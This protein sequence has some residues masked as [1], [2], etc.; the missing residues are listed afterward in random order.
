VQDDYSPGY[1]LPSEQFEDELTEMDQEDVKYAM[2]FDKA[3]YLDHVNQCH[4]REVDVNGDPVRTATARLFGGSSSQQIDI[5]RSAVSCKDGNKPPGAVP[6]LFMSRWGDNDD[7]DFKRAATGQFSRPISYRSQIYN[8][9]TLVGN[10]SRGGLEN[11]DLGLFRNKNTL[12][13]SVAKKWNITF[14]KLKL[15]YKNTR[16]TFSNFTNMVKSA[17]FRYQYGGDQLN[18][19]QNTI[20]YNS[21]ATWVGKKPE[22]LSP[23]N[24]HYR[25]GDKSFTQYVFPDTQLPRA[26]VFIQFSSLVGAQ[27]RKQAAQQL[28]E[29]IQ[30]KEVKLG[31]IYADEF[32]HLANMINPYLE[33]WELEEKRLF[34][35]TG[36]PPSTYQIRVPSTKEEFVTFDW[37]IMDDFYNTGGLLDPF[38]VLS[39]VMY[40]YYMHCISIEEALKQKGLNLA[41]VK[42]DICMSCNNCKGKL[43]GDEAT[44]ELANLQKQG[45]YLNYKMD[46]VNDGDGV[47]KGILSYN[48]ITDKILSNVLGANNSNRNDLFE[49]SKKITD[50]PCCYR[51][52]DPSYF[53]KW[54]EI[55]D[56]DYIKP[57][58]SFK[59]MFTALL[60]AVFI[61][62]KSG[63]TVGSANPTPCADLPMYEAEGCYSRPDCIADNDKCRSKDDL[64]K[65]QLDGTNDVVTANLCIGCNSENSCTV[66]NDN[67]VW[68][69]DQNMCVHK[70]A[71]KIGDECLGDSDCI[72]QGTM[73]LDKDIEK[74]TCIPRNPDSF[75]TNSNSTTEP[76]TI[77]WYGENEPR[78]QTPDSNF[79]R[80]LRSS[81]GEVDVERLRSN[82][83]G[84]ACQR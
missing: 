80:S 61:A 66:D 15:L 35:H 48:N 31:E 37:L 39:Y 53:L 2:T 59:P 7:E 8:A 84:A 50:K 22:L 52:Q 46:S 75:Y 58:L 44:K 82:R 43:T 83:A 73:G 19:I 23:F 76:E 68:L 41:R 3:N 6:C 51:G 65:T 45:I 36:L 72:L 1:C 5:K 20:D 63:T 56:K 47:M 57:L 54:F 30:R 78:S 16:K 74:G 9:K 13:Y 38:I 12:N 71:Q 79:L 14:T 21:D 4:M 18:F 34:Q 29:R 60:N 49:V 81:R 42:A 33:K 77:Q 11:N 62:K 64:C 27:K 10:L 67:C 69:G 28:S 32:A 17:G 24:S 70:C 55:Y 25:P 26:P 40:I